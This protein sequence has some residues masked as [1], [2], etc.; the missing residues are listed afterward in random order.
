MAEGGS[1]LVTILF[2]DVVGSTELL[3]RA[4]DEEA[5]RIFQAHHQLLSEAVAAHGGHEVKWLGDGLMVAF[6][7]AADALTC[8]ISMQQAAQR[9]VAGER[10]A[11]RVGL[12]AGEALRDAVDYFGTPVVLA[13]RLCDQAG[14][15]QILCSEVV[16]GLLAG[17]PG[18]TFAAAGE[19][20]L[21]GLPQPV[22]A[23]EVRY[24]SESR[25]AAYREAPLVGRDTEL[26]RLTE[27]VREAAGGR[28]GLVLIAGEPGIGKTRLAQEAAAQAEREG[29]FVLWG[30]GFEGEW[31]PPY[32]PFAEA[33]TPHI[34]LSAPDE[35]RSDLG[36]GAEPLCQLVPRIREVLPDLPE[37]PSV[38][39]EEERF[40]LLDAMA[41]FLIARSRRAP[42]LLVL[43]DLQWADRSTVAMLRHLVRFAPKER[44]L[45]LGAYPDIELDPGHPL[46]DLLGVVAREAGYE[47]LHLKGLAP[48]DVTRLLAALGGH[49]VEEKVGEAWLRQTEGNPFFILELLRHLIEEGTLYQDSEGRW[50]TTRRLADLG[51][52]QRV[53]DVVIRRLAR[54]SKGTNQLLQAAAAFDRTFRFDVVQ[55]MAGLPELDALDALDEALAA[56]VLVPTGAAETYAFIRNLIRETIHEGIS[57]SRQIRLHRRAAEALE[58][59]PGLP[60]EAQAEE[61]AVQY[62]RSLALAG[63]ERGVEFALTAAAHAQATG[64]YDEAAGFLRMALDMA[65]DD[66]DRRPRLTA[67]LAIVKAWALAFEETVELAVGAAGTIAEVE[68]KQAAAEYLSDAAHVCMLAGNTVAAWKLAGPGLAYASSR[69]VAWARLFSFDEERRAAEAPEYPGIPLESTERA[70]AAR[71]LRA[72]RLD[73]LGPAPAEAVWSSRDEALDSDNLVVQIYWLGEYVAALPRFEAEAEDAERL[74]RLARAVRAWSGAASCHAALGRLGDARAALSRAGDLAARLGILVFPILWA[75]DV[76]VGAFGEGWEELFDAYRPL[77]GLTNPAVAWAMGFILAVAARAAARTGHPDEAMNVLA[78]LV[79]WLERAPAWTSGFPVMACHAAET[80][81]ELERL[82]HADVVECALREKVIRP[83][84]RHAMVDGRLGLARLCALTGRQDEAAGWFEDARRVL[85]PQGEAPLLAIADYDEALMYARRG[86]PGDQDRARAL[87]DSA[88]RRFEPLGMTGWLHRAEALAARI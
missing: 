82:D 9:P 66:D 62:H 37:M 44:I 11:I 29:A 80:L 52:P 76:V 79:P 33:L 25:P 85:T 14:A 17:R 71:I 83:D 7:S 81:W 68:G 78:R 13:K 49:A 86:D 39:P 23:Y 5:R 57:P 30:R 10:V 84:L 41:Q 32:V 69:N 88:T 8:A 73:P 35:L 2:T 12:T 4:G 6:P 46:S 63:A 74:G 56:H 58:A 70:E 75:R 27:R 65:P 72:A 18:F 31:A 34:A 15:G 22:A 50:I 3:S 1:G 59:A 26:A 45:L 42:V 43:D 54:L 36:A 87:L 21:K 67:R 24:E 48:A 53:R 55:E 64:G 40:R 38:P 16:A 20:E 77:V 47:H 28:G 19:F 60:V 61:I 51:V